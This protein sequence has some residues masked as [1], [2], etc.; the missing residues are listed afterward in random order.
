MKRLLCGLILSC[1]SPCIL[2]AQD[3][4]QLSGSFETSS[5]YYFK[6]DKSG[7]VIPKDKFASNNYLKFDYFYKNF[8]VGVQFEGYY[9][10]LQGYSLQL[11]EG[12]IANKYLRFADKGF[13][14]VVGDFYEQFGNGLIFRTYE[15]RALGFNNSL[16]GVNGCYTNGFLS[17]KGMWGRQRKYMDYVSG[18]LRGFDAVIWL[19]EVL[20]L[21]LDY[22]TIEGSWVEK[23]ELSTDEAIPSNVDAYSAR[24]SLG[25]GI[26]SL[27]AEYVEKSKDPIFLNNYATSRGN[28]LLVDLGIHAGGFG[29][30]LMGRRL[31]NMDFRSERSVAELAST[32][33]YLPALTRQHEYAL[34][35]LYPYATQA[36]GEIGGQIDLY[37]TFSS[38]QR[39]SPGMMIHLN[40]S[41]YNNLKRKDIDSYEFLAMGKTQLFQDLNFDIQKHFGRNVKMVLAGTYQKLDG[42]ILGKPLITYETFTGI[43]DLTFKLN[44]TNSIRIEGQHQWS[45]KNDKNWVYGQVEYN[46]APSWSFYVNDMYNYGK[47]KIH[48]YNTG[49]SYTKSRTRVALSYARNRAGYQ[50]SGGVCRMMPAFTGFNLALTSSF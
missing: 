14:V 50:C 22:F 18:N 3:R 23:H 28:A 29:M 26:F 38:S 12:K 35:N 43:V 39:K 42:E 47:T 16:E 19:N 27:K 24:V 30:Q 13:E 32:I 21:P 1:L 11:K 2:Q 17:L 48:Y 5:A 40:Y 7:V 10:V 37:Y 44:Q 36:N 15:D 20:T 33:N 46:V 8:S 41:T 45:D 49:F 34:A 31:E 6:D 25:K 9:P 4:G